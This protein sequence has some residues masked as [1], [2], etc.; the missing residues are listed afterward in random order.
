[1]DR[2][3]TPLG[4]QL[5]SRIRS[6][7]PLT[8]RDFMAAALYDEKLGF[9]TEGPR[10]GEIE[11]PFD[12]N[13]KFPAFGYALAKAILQSEKLLGLELR[14]LELGGGTGELG[15]FINSFLPTPR[16]Y[17]VLERSCGLRG[18]QENKGLRTLKTLKNF[19]A[20]PTF[21]FGNEVLDALP[22]HRVM[23]GSEN[24]LFE[25]Y[26]DLD[27]KGE[28]CE[29]LGPLSTLELGKRLEKIG[30]SLG[31]GQIA[32][33]CLEYRS[34]LKDIHHVVDSGY[35]I[36]VDYGDIA[37]NLYSYQR[38][39]G[40]LRSYY[41]QNQIFDPFF[42]VGQQDLTADV[43]FS[44]VILDAKELGWEF[45]GLIDQGTWLNNVGIQ[46]FAQSGT[47]RDMSERDL[48]FLTGPARLGSTFD[49]LIFHTPGSPPGPGLNPRKN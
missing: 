45:S 30:V 10:I 21:A 38:R 46:G 8:F 27:E 25:F 34:F 22:V 23:G 47:D 48:Q 43:D 29:Q 18:I 33:V 39:N 37:S 1:M 24:Q 44:G 11:G 36:F 6:E 16:E 42:S 14:I 4:L 17:V 35:I 2:V 32:E 49:V 12:T 15:D 9:Y 19:P 5:K 3:E 13:A 41:S 20:K 40:S 26:V 31:R 28:F 7:G